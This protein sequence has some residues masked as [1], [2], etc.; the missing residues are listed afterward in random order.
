MLN[1]EMRDLAIKVLDDPNGISSLAW[2]ALYKMLSGLGDN[3]DIIAAV[4]KSDGRVYL[5][6]EH[7]VEV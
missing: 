5:P 6:D 2:E 4:K 1:D 7:G 3:N